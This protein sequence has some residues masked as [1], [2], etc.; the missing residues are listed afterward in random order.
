MIDR[1]HKLGDPDRPFSPMDPGHLRDAA[2]G[3]EEAQKMLD[4]YS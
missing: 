3:A 4:H 2:D 1:V